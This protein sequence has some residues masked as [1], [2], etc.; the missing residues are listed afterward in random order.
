MRL[1]N[2]SVL[3]NSEN[4]H[5]AAF[6]ELRNLGNQCVPVRADFI[7]NLIQVWTEVVAVRRRENLRL[8]RG[9]IRILLNVGSW[10]T[11]TRTL[12]SID[13]E[14]PGFLRL[15]LQNL[16]GKIAEAESVRVRILRNLRG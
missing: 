13:W 9:E 5:H 10:N 2:S 6:S 15:L 14:T 1:P 7:E 8:F 4:N 12:I 11:G 3:L 16:A